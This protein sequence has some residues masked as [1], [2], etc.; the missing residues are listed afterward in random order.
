MEIS[1]TGSHVCVFASQLEE[2]CYKAVGSFRSSSL[3][4]RNKLLWIGLD[5]LEPGTTSWLASWIRIQEVMW[6]VRLLPGCYAFPAWFNFCLSVMGCIPLERKLKETLSHLSCFLQCIL[7]CQQ[8]KKQKQ[9]GHR[10][11]Y[12]L[13][14]TAGKEMKKLLDG[15]KT[16]CFFV[17]YFLCQWRL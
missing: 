5:V 9:E 15:K 6:P 14:L 8:K 4:E 16:V 17:I 7:S 1:H 3:A 13:G 12:S 10:Q 11:N 2:L